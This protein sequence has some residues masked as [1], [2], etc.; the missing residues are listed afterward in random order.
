MKIN[1]DFKP[2]RL[3]T[4]RELYTDAIWFNFISLR[5]IRPS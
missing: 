4:M 5:I 3:G 2:L 1:V